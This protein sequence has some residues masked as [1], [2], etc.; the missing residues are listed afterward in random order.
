M[1]HACAACAEA[2]RECAAECGK[3]DSAEMRACASA[4][5]ECEQTCRTMVKFGA[6][7]CMT[8]DR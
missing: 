4:C 3:F 5:R 2:C 6:M 1:A 7:R 8:T